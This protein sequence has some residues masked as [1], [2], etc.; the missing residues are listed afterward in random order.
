MNKIEFLANIDKYKGEDHSTFLQH[1]GILGQKWGQRRWQ[2]PDGTFNEEGKQRY[3][4]QKSNNISSEEKIGGYTADHFHKNIYLKTDKNTLKKIKKYPDIYDT[5]GLTD[6]EI[7]KAVRRVP[8]I[9]NARAY[10]REI[11]EELYNTQLNKTRSKYYETNT[12]DILE[13]EDVE[14]QK[15]GGW[16]D[17]GKKIDELY[18]NDNGH[19]YSDNLYT[20]DEQEYFM[21]EKNANRINKM[22][23]YAMEGNTK[24]YDKLMDKIDDKYKDTVRRAVLDIEDGIDNKA[25]NKKGREL[26]KEIGLGEVDLNAILRN[27]YKDDERM[28]SIKDRDMIRNNMDTIMTAVKKLKNQDINGYYDEVEKIAR[29]GEDKDTIDRFVD[30]YISIKSYIDEGKKLDK[31]LKN[32]KNIQS[33]CKYPIDYDTDARDFMFSEYTKDYRSIQEKMQDPKIHRDGQKVINNLNK[34]FDKYVDQFKD[35]V[36]ENLYEDYKDWHADDDKILSKQQ[37]KNAIGKVNSGSIDD[38]GYLQLYLEDN[39]LFYG[40][41]FTSLGVIDDNGNLK[42]EDVFLEG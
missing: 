19:L 28:Y 22:A 14:E 36:V 24:K 26:S 20:S 33:K 31:E 18:P 13:A 35:K 30:D 10:G 40:H 7:L 15:I 41:V 29:T 17:H 23:K 25:N 6:D 12:K 21:N 38:T 3:F 37:F 32:M 5:E 1:Y 4:G 42:V 2:N 11:R 39:G 9:P 27:R 34:N 8:K 16:T